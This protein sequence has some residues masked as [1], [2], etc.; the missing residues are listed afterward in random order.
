MDEMNPITR[1]SRD[2]ANA[3]ITL[4]EQEARYLVDSYYQMQDNR[5]RAYGQIRAMGETYEPHSV[6][7]WLAEQ[8]ETL[9][10]QVQRA[11]DKYSI[12]HEIGGWLRGVIGIG[13]VIAAGLLAH[14]DIT[15]AATAG[16]IWRFAGLDPTSVW[17]KGQKRPFNARLK[18][19]CWKAGESFVKN[20]NHE[21]CF[22]GHLYKERKAQEL[23]KNE[24][25]M[26]AEV[27]ADI[28]T[29]R[30][31]G[32]DTEAYKAYSVGKLPPAHIHARAR[33]Y[34]VKI[35]LSHL[36]DKLYRA[37]YKKPPPVPYPIAI[38]EHAHYIAPEDY[39]DTE[40]TVD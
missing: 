1:L 15:R 9:E 16:S 5:I 12:N 3:A 34:A 30:K 33:R 36:H 8:S 21:R 39:D 38:L 13:P 2:L 7:A 37:H 11:L 32:H 22:Y 27:A 20:S 29:K 19:L 40:P 6:L 28:L 18:V 23:A 14:I 35:F 4:S 25:G 10:K 17:A 24:A 26:F 31:I